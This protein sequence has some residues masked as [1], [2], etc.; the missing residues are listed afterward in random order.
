MLA[1]LSLAFIFTT[2]TSVASSNVLGFHLLPTLLGSC[3]NV[4]TVKNGD[5]AERIAADHGITL[6]Q[7]LMKN[8]NIFNPDILFIGQ[9][10]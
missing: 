2:I 4:Y 9:V 3:D 8:R 10:N 6:D 7:L 1:Q 5:T